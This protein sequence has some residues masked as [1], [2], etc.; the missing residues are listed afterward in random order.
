M[1]SHDFFK[2]RGMGSY[3]FFKKEEYEA[4]INQIKELADVYLAL[5][6]R[7]LFNIDRCDSLVHRKEFEKVLNDLNKGLVNIIGSKQPATPMG[8]KARGVVYDV[9]ADALRKKESPFQRFDPSDGS[10]E[11]S[12]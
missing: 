4:L 3:D 12:N 2:K 10:S 5:R 7:I 8:A 11:W 6:E 1:G 9:V